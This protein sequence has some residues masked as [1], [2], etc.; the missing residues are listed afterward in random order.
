VLAVVAQAEA[1]AISTR[2]KD[3]LKVACKRIAATGAAQSQKVR[4]L[5]NPNGVAALRRAKKG[6][7]TAVATVQHHAKQRALDLAP[8]VVA[9]QADGAVTLKA[10]AKE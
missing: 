2:I 1:K 4:R 6:N 3:A 5:G 9:I 10:I 7:V 8:V